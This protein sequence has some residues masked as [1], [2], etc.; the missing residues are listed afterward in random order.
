M[1][2]SSYDAKKTLCFC[3]SN[4]LMGNEENAQTLV[5]NGGINALVNLI[6]DEEDDELSNKAY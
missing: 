1:K 6:N 2:S 5:Q 3:L 4:L